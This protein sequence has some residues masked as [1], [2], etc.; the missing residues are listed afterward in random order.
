MRKILPAVIRTVHIPVSIDTYKSDVASLA[1]DHG[2]TIVN[3]VSGLCYDKNMANVIARHR[4]GLVIMHMK[5][6]PKTMQLDSSW[7]M[8]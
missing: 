6:T 1:I 2:V 7:A 8:V 3:D 5:G 4:V